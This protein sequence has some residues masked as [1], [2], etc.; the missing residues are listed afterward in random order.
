MGPLVSTGVR[1]ETHR[2]SPA[3]MFT[4]DTVLFFNL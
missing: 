2:P 3:V 4:K 1:S